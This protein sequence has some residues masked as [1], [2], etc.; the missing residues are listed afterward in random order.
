MTPVR[1]LSR[2]SSFAP[3]TYCSINPDRALNKTCVQACVQALQASK[4][5]LRFSRYTLHVQQRMLG[6]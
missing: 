6:A 2:Q 1:Q 5:H 4:I 3:R